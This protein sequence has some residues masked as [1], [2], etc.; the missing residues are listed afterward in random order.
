MENTKL[1]QAAE[2]KKRWSR[3]R[4]PSSRWTVGASLALAVGVASIGVAPAFA[5]D[6]DEN[7][8]E[9]AQ[10][11]LLYFDANQAGRLDDGN[12]FDWR[13]DSTLG[14]GSDVGLDL[15]G[16]Y[17]DAGD[18]VK[19]G[20]PAGATFAVMAWSSAQYEDCLLYTSDA[21]DE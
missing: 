4:L 3:R 21:A 5:Q 1:T 19:F 2:P 13:F 16:G 9:A 11:A 14:D 18:H 12:R 7:Y 10:L 17:F 8:A 20:Q 6:P 15:T